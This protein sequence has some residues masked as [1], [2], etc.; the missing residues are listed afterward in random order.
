EYSDT[1]TSPAAL[2]VVKLNTSVYPTRKPTSS[3][4]PPTFPMR[5]ASISPTCSVQLG[6][7]WSTR[8]CG[9]ETSW[10]YGA[11]GPSG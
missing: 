7:A 8:T 3:L 9:R 5:R 11:L 1:P 4:S 10:R 2:P 6:T